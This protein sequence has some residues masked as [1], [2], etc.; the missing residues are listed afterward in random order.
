MPGTANYDNLLYGTEFKFYNS[1][2]EVNNEFETKYKRLYV[3]GDASGTT[4]SLSQASSEGVF[5]AR[6]IGEK[7]K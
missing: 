7:E 3:I 5:V 4:H 1:C 6:I 2:I